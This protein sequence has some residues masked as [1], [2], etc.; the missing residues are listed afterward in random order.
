[1]QIGAQAD[2]YVQF[3]AQ[4]REGSFIVHPVVE[5][6]ARVDARCR[7]N[8]VGKTWKDVP[9][10]HPHDRHRRSSGSIRRGHLE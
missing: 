4:L 5:R 3:E 6:R 8:L 2:L 1:M 9:D 10:G 7:Q